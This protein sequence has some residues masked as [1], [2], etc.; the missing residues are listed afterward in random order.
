MFKSVISLLIIGMISISELSFGQS[1]SMNVITTS[2]P[3]LRISSDARTGAMG[4]VGISTTPDANSSFINLAKIPFSSKHAAIGVNYAA[5]MKSLGLQD[6]YLASITGYFKFDEIE[7]FSSSFR[8]FNLGNEQFT[9]NQGSNLNTHRPSEFSL[10][11]GYTRKLSSNLAMGIA[12]RFINSNLAK[13]ESASGGFYKTGNAI[14]ADLSLFHD[15]TVGKKDNS[16]LNWGVALT[17]LGSKISYTNNASRKDYIPA[18]L[19]LGVAYIKAFDPGK[20]L[21]VGLDVNKLLVPTPPQQNDPAA[22]DEYYNKSVVNSWFSAFGKKAGGFGETIR[23]FQVSTGAE[24]LYNQ[25]FAF[26]GG[27][28]YENAQKGNRKYF[29]IG[30][31][32]EYKQFEVN[33][34]YLIPS[35]SNVNQNPLSNTIRFGLIIKMD[36]SK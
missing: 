21:I 5:W 10:E 19:G 12:I 34:S 31:G 20:K 24:F 23:E 32:I 27:Y 3:F 14:A 25:Q 11:E 16:G 13:G 36:K 7:A 8:Y 17:N 35:G 28:F 1:N 30:A 15:G 22:M 26:R 9:D 33:F 6:V 29:T 2:V 18:N 4:D